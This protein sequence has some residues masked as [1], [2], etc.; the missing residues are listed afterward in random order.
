M[1]EVKEEEAEGGK[2]ACLTARAAETAEA[3]GAE[4]ADEGGETE[5]FGTPQL[6]DHVY[7]ALTGECCERF[8]G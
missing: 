1:E 7:T 4:T 6:P 3:A 8:R 5:A 2:A